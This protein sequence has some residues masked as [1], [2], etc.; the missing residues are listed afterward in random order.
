MYT[1]QALIP[2]IPFN[3]LGV[4]INVTPSTFSPYWLLFYGKM[5]ITS[6]MLS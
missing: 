5:F 4:E 6:T 2:L 3:R 1:N